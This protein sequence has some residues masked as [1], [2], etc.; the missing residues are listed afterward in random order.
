MGDSSKKPEYLV[1]SG[2]KKRKPTV[3]RHLFDGLCANCTDRALYDY[4]FQQKAQAYNTN[5]FKNN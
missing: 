1:C 4:S 3:K 2:C 5:N